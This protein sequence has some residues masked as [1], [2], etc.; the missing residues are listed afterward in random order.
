MTRTETDAAFWTSEDLF[1]H[2]LHQKPLFVLDVRNRKE[3]ARWKIPVSPSQSLLNIPYFEILER[4]GRDDV[5]ESAIAFAK[6]HLKEVL[7]ANT[8]ILCVCAKGDT[9]EFIAEALRRLSYHASNLKGGM[10][11][12]A[13]LYILQPIVREASFSLYQVQRPSRGCLSYIVVSEGEAAVVD[14]LRH[15]EKYT[16]WAKAHGWEITLLLDTHAHADH[17]SGGT[18]L[19]RETGAPYYLHPYDGIHPI[20]VLPARCDFRFIRDRSVFRVGSASIQALHIPG[21][22]LGNTAFWV[23]EEYLLS[24]DS[25]FI[26]SIARPD[27]GGRAET[28]AHLHYSSLQKLLALPDETVLLPGHYTELTEANPEGIFATSLASLRAQNSSVA[29]LSFGE[30]KFVEYVLHSLPEFPPEYVDIKRV[31]LGLKDASEQIAEELETG[32]NIC[33]LSGVVS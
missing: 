7:P 11:E 24:G 27:L 20:D 16:A 30:E 3:F 28:W 31:N 21:H 5:V 25:L 12:W 15:T 18:K 32:Q 22:T 2:L 6:E 17:I 1:Q 19:S 23:N 26:Q 10:R 9:S 14:P 8:P 33:A 13:N 4:G 29:T